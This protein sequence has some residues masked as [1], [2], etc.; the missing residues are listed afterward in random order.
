MSAVPFSG[1]FFP[2]TPHPSFVPSPWETTRKGST[3]KKVRRR[4][5]FRLA[6]KCTAHSSVGVFTPTYRTRD[7]FGIPWERGLSVWEFGSTWNNFFSKSPCKGSKLLSNWSV[8]KNNNTD[9]KIFLSA[10][11]NFYLFTCWFTVSGFPRG[12]K[13]HVFF[14]SAARR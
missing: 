13:V 12:T 6:K 8:E 2:S 3:R 4:D 9:W 5:R 1:K 11:Y 10:R 7:F 14:R